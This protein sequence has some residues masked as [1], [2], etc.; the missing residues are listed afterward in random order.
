MQLLMYTDYA[1]RALVYVGTHPARPVSA[2]TIAQAYQIS[3]DHVAKATKALTREGLLHATRGA[4]GGVQLAKPASEIQIGTVVRLF[5][6]NRGVVDCAGATARPCRIA[7]SCRLRD[8]FAEAEEA[9]YE[10]LDRYTLADVV[11]NR[12]QLVQLLRGGRRS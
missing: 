6:G 4:G 7:A 8:A 2:V 10:I 3:T 11:H 5:E 12:P 9:F 1:L